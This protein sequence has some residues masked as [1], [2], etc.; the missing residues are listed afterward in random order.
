MQVLFTRPVMA[1][2]GHSYEW[3]AIR[4]WLRKHNTS[5]MTR[6]HLADKTLRRNFNLQSQLKGFLQRHPGKAP[7]P[8]AVDSEEVRSFAKLRILC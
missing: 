2:D 3:A 4:R 6:E 7:Q 5:P 8:A 1:S